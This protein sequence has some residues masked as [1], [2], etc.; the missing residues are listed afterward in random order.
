MNQ[1]SQEAIINRL[2]FSELDKKTNTGSKVDGLLGN[3]YKT[4]YNFLV[5]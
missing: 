4:V 1:P 2:L 5:S 3:V